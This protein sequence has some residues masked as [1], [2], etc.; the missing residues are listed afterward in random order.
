M[1]FGRLSIHTAVGLLLAA[2]LLFVLGSTRAEVAPSLDAG[3]T[4]LATDIVAKS[5]EKDRHK[6]AV[7]PFPNTDGTCSVLSNFLVDKLI[8]SLFQVPDSGQTIVE[9]S[10]L[11]ALLDELEMGEKGLLDASTTQKLGSIHGVQALILGSITPSTN[12]IDVTAR[13]VAT[14]TGAVFASASTTFPRTSDITEWLRQPVTTGANCGLKGKR[15]ATSAAAVAGAQVQA[16][17]S[18]N[19]DKVQ[20][21]TFEEFRF[22]FKS[23]RTE[24]KTAT[25]V[26]A[27]ANTS[28]HPSAFILA[29]PEP[30]LEDGEGNQ[31]KL[32][33]VK[34]VSRCQEKYSSGCIFT[35]ADDFFP[36][37][38]DKQR[39]VTMRFKGEA[40]LS[41]AEFWL[42]ATVQKKILSQLEATEVQS[43]HS[44]NRD[45]PELIV[46]GSGL[47]VDIQLSIPDLAITP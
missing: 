31:M 2:V 37:L 19:S 46:M 33:D 23:V 16:A 45:A 34:G 11:E 28:N 32:T 14:D 25:V 8:N 4:Q 39:I 36:L 30:I 22:E 21:Y 26:M 17:D 10:Q 47:A 29:V 3:L 43:R 1:Q 5:K 12:Q 15:V 42:R 40:P 7:L 38:P 18:E 24:G 13:L 44:K 9:R 27:V 35:H 20:T 6:I 41:G